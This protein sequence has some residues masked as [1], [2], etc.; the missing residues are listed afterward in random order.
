M[1]KYAILF[2][3]FLCGCSVA[4]IRQELFGLDIN[5]LKSAKQ[6]CTD[7]FDI[8]PSDCF[9]KVEGI[10]SEMDATVNRKDTERLFLTASN[11]NNAY[12]Y[13]INTT[14]LAVLIEADGPDKSRVFIFSKNSSLAK[15]VSE[16][17]FKKL[18]E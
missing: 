11:F 15:F 10:I 4:Q 9:S 3:I 8:K 17:V 18:R 7:V 5:D 16:E 14:S 2:L 13:C 12:S 6:K 1:R